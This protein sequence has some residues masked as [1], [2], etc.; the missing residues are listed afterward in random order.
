MDTGRGVGVCASPAS[1][2]SRSATSGRRHGAR[3]G[4]PA[5][6]ADAPGRAAAGDAVLHAR[7]G[8]RPRFARQLVLGRLHHLLCDRRAGGARR[9][10]RPLHQVRR[11][12][13]GSG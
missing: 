5:P 9:A 13:A 6:T 4:T 10:P 3:P 11:E 12:A 7:R 8:F 2:H 1:L